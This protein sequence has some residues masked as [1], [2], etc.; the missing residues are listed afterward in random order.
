M[1]NNVHLVK[2]RLWIAQNTWILIHTKFEDDLLNTSTVIRKTIF[3]QRG[4]LSRLST[5]NLKGQDTWAMGTYYIILNS[6][7]VCLGDLE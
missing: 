7:L 4:V 6:D 2:V 5:I 1:V 3:K